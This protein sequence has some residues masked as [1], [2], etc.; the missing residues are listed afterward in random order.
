MPKMED[1]DNF[2]VQVQEEVLAE[3]H[4]AQDS[5]HNIRDS[6]RAHHIARGKLCS[7]L[8]K[9]PNLEDYALALK[10][11]DDKQAYLAREHIIDLRN[12]YAVLTDILQKNIAKIRAPKGNNSG[13]MY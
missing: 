2:G 9:Y 6:V 12:I 1:G 4:R 3:V 10:N 5:S 7:K 11:H 13:S 8:L